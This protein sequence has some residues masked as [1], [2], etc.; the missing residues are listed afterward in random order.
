M[1]TPTPPFAAL[2]D[3][4]A[5]TRHLLLDFDGVVCR[6]YATHPP[7]LAA[8]RLRALLSAH[9]VPIPEAITATAD[10]LA[11]LSFA[12]TISRELAEQADAELTDCELG[13]V[14]TAQPVGYVHDVI[15]SAR[16]SG[17]TV[18]VIST[19][20]ARAVNAYL[21]RTNLADLAGLGVARTPYDPASTS[22]PSLIGRSTG[23]LD[24]DTSACAV[25]ASSADVLDAALKTGAAVIAYA[26]PPATRS[27]AHAH[28]HA[29]AIVTSLADLALRLRARPLRN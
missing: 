22:V 8:D 18:T 10:P 24:T 14:P 1:T 3:I 6:L 23:L 13:A 7:S 9:G 29:G 25:V 5:R 2:D 12:G 28:A 21:E 20:S 15:A 26:S 16:E 19:C 17:R 4:L 27:R 11:V